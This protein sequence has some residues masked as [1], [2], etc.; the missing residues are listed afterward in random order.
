MRS[1]VK[2]TDTRDFIIS[3]KA[4]CD[5]YNSKGG[6]FAIKGTILNPLQVCMEFYV[7]LADYELYRKDRGEDEELMKPRGKVKIANPNYQ[8]VLDSFVPHETV[9]LYQSIISDTERIFSGNL[10]APQIIEYAEGI[11]EKSFGSDYIHLYLC[12]KAFDSF[13]QSTARHSLSVY[14]L[15]CEVML[16]I[17]KRSRDLPFYSLFKQRG[18]KINFSSDQ[19]RHYSIGALLHD[20]GK[21]KIPIN[22]LEKKEPLTPEESQLMYR[23]SNYGVEILEEVGNFPLEI[24]EMVGNHHQFYPVYPEIQRS[25]LV[26]ILSILDIFDAC[27]TKRPYKDAFS[28][29]ECEIILQESKRKY[30]WS[31]YLLQQVIEGTLRKFETQIIMMDNRCTETI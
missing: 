14:L 31:S 16:D 6:L 20:I 1:L 25:P 18:K 2:L 13:N 24:K 22:L 26:E 29:K 21:I 30:G 5:L 23:H 15:F 12:N 9:V 3:S 27:R 4:V 8:S 17:R 28:F 19:I 11:I 7:R 10:S